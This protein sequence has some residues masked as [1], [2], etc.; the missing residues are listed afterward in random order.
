MRL[1]FKTQFKIRVLVKECL[2]FP[3]RSTSI[4]FSV[5]SGAS[6]RKMILDDREKDYTHKLMFNNLAKLKRILITQNSVQQLLCHFSR[7]AGSIK[8]F[9]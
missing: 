3:L 5:H 1:S 4:L 6:L 8:V 9:S 2:E 7:S